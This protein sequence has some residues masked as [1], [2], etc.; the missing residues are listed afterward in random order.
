MLLKVCLR[1][2]PTISAALVGQ[3]VTFDRIGTDGEQV[4]CT[5]WVSCRVVCWLL[6]MHAYRCIIAF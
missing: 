3:G 4:Y 1:L 2:Y 5:W 6:G